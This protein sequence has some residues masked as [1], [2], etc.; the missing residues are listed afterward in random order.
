M[1]RATSDEQERWKGE[2]LL[3]K[4][5]PGLGAQEFDVDGAAK[6]VPKGSDI[7]IQHPLHRDRQACH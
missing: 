4:F 2:N 7:R 1:K 6:F 5:N 3:G